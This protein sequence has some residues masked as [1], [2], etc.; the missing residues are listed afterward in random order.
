MFEH[1]RAPLLPRRVFLR[2]QA[3]CAALGVA[4]LAGA[5][6]LGT[7]GYHGIAGLDWLEAEL[8]AAMILT[9]MGPV[10]QLATPAAKIFAS[11]YALFSGVAFLAAMAAISA[12]LLHR[13]LHRFHL[14]DEDFAP[15]ERHGA[16]HAPRPGAPA[17]G[18]PAG[19]GPPGPQAV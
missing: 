8:N 11:A 3:R 14:A 18:A 4:L 5:L 13:M 15:R 6:G 10:D 7:L 9:G 1:R 12:P 2:R 17:A 16:A 19:A